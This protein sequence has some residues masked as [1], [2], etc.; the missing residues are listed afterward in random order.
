[1]LNI[2]QNYTNDIISV[3][4]L[5]DELTKNHGPFKISADTVGD[6]GEYKRIPVGEL[7]VDKKVYV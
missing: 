1:M 7:S 2:N 6:A 4:E 5:A 3:I